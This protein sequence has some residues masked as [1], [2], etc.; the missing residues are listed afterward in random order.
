MASIPL[1]ILGAMPDPTA[2]NAPQIGFNSGSN[3]P[4]LAFDAATDQRA[5]WTFRLPD[6]Y[7]STPELHIQWGA[8]TATTGNVVWATEVMALTTN[9]DRDWETNAR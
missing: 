8:D 1:A 4:Y 7:S 6:D 2:A 5:V 9:T 3:R